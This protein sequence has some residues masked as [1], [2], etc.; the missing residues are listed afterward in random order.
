MTSPKEAG[1]RTPWQRLDSQQQI[2]RERLLADRASAAQSRARRRWRLRLP[3][4]FPPAPQ[5]DSPAR[6][7]RG[8]DES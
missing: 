7:D 8:A 1:A 5:D 6:A 4:T 2:D 3:A